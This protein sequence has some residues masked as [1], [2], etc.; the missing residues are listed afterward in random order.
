MHEPWAIALAFAVG[1]ISS[2]AWGRWRF[3]VVHELRAIRRMLERE[4][5]PTLRAIRDVLLRERE[6]PP[7]GRGRGDSP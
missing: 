5:E 3:Q 2:A 1:V 6:N 4:Q 7:D